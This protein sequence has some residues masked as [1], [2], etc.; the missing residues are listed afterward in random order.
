[1][2]RKFLVIVILSC[3]LLSSC[4]KVG[5]YGFDSTKF[6]PSQVWVQRI[7]N[8]IATGNVEKTKRLV[9]NRIYDID[10]VFHVTGRTPL[11]MACMHGELEVIKILVENGADVNLGDEGDNRPLDILLEDF[12]QSDKEA[13]VYL[14]ENGADFYANEFTS[15]L[16]LIGNM[17]LGEKEWGEIER[18]EYCEAKGKEITELFKAA[19]DICENKT[20]CDYNGDLLLGHA[21]SG[22]N[23]E[24][25]KYIIDEL[26]INVNQTDE[27]DCTALFYINDDSKTKEWVESIVNVLVENGIDINHKNDFDETA[28]DYAIKEEYH[29]LAELVKP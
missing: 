18:D 27:M 29:I 16:C 1:M 17:W 14:C 4:N 21:A 8:A 11:Q 5:P 12:H 25:M 15:P 3:V 7:A 22:G 20:S 10:T 23:L 9:E 6:T 28:Y 2:K 19:L 13:M 26:D 24:L